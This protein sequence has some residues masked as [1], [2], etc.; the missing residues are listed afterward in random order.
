MV[1]ITITGRVS[2]N[3]SSFNNLFLLGMMA[4]FDINVVITARENSCKIGRA[5][6]SVWLISYN[7]VRAS[8]DI[9]INRRWSAPV[10]YVTTQEN[11]LIY[12]PVPWSLSTLPLMYESLKPYDIS[13]ICD[14]RISRM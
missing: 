2:H 3:L 5:S 1:F 12:R 4:N 11:N 14:H 7:A 13:F 6:Y 9:V 10:Q 8:A